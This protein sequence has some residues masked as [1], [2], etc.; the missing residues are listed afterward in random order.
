MNID[1]FTLCLL[2]ILVCEPNPC[3]HG[4]CTTLGTGHYYCKCEP[5][6]LKRKQQLEN[7]F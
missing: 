4:V 1:Q 6:K 2:I 7:V 5:G 3:L